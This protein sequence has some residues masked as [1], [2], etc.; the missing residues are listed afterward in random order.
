MTRELDK[1]DQKNERL[2]T[3]TVTYQPEIATLSSQFSRMPPGAIG[4]VVDNA[5]RPEILRELRRLSATFGL[6]LIVNEENLGL[7]AATNKGIRLAKEI[8]CGSVLLLD[9]DTVPERGGVEALMNAY[10]ELRCGGAVPGCIGP[11]MVDPVTGLE[12]GF[13]RLKGWRWVREFPPVGTTSPLACSNL[14]GSGTLIPMWLIDE[15][16]GLDEALFIDH[17]D[18]EW[19]FRVQSA[20]FGV[21]GAPG[22]TFS[23]RM[24]ERVTRFWWLRWRL[25]PYRSPLRHRYLFRN[26]TA[27]MRREY[28]PRVWKIW[29]V[30]KLL[31]TWLVHF[32]FDG[33]RF[34]Q[35]AEML[36]GIRDGLRVPASRQEK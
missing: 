36:R 25:W 15:L 29:A 4:I 17:V 19:A 12:H 16:G 34:A 28:V 31:I 27:L 11:R 14:N 32:A 8:G 21:Y 18:T 20:G 3:I 24:G 23:H 6:E 10:R 1:L 26:A 13:H 7:A 33:R 30:L 5:S 2:A 9:Q 22:V 35:T